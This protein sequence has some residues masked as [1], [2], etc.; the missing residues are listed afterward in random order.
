MSRMSFDKPK[1][2][3]LNQEKVTLKRNL[4]PKEQIQK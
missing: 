1:S 3:R 4:K 2:Q